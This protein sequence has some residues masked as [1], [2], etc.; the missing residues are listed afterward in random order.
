MSFSALWKHDFFKQLLLFSSSAY[1]II[2][3]NNYYCRRHLKSSQLCPVKTVLT[4][5]PLF[6]PSLKNNISNSF[7]S[8]IHP[9]HWPWAH[10]SCPCRLPSVC[11]A[12][13]SQWKISIL[14]CWR[15]KSSVLVLSMFKLLWLLMSLVSLFINHPYVI[16]W[17][18][19]LSFTHFSVVFPCFLLDLCINSL[20]NKLI[21]PFCYIFAIYFT[22]I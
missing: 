6:L 1:I 15:V 8:W 20:W 3:V 17:Y 10:C 7:H 16:F 4:Q 14:L 13:F 11:A 19:F 22:F 9:R 12:S 5:T 21:N 18:L 2:I